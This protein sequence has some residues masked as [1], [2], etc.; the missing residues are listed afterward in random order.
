MPSHRRRLA[1]LL[2]PVALLAAAC[3]SA[4]ANPD[5]AA[6]VNGVQI[7]VA[8]VDERFAALQENPQTAEQLAND[9]DGTV[10]AQAQ[11]EL[12]SDL[13]RTTLL[14]QAAQEEFDFEVSEADVAEQRE[15]VVEQLGGQEAFDAFVEEQGLTEDEVDLQLRQLAL[16]AGI[17]ERLGEDEGNQVT[18]EEVSSYYEENV[19]RASAPPRP[20]AT[21]LSRTRRRPRAPW[22]G[23]TAARTSPPSPPSCPPTPAAPS[24][25]GSWARSSAAPRS[26]SSRR[27]PS[28]RPSARRPARSRPSSASTSSR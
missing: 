11:A 1:A 21:S 15:L 12:L 20:S 17:T 19:T 9:P 23:S 26:R 3:G 5:V 24:R 10:A 14:E 18:D 4:G 27:R 7:T 8:Q 22:T 13:I 25:A 2:V 6:T 28:A 16:N